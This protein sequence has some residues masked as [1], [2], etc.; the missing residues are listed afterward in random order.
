MRKTNITRRRKNKFHQ[1]FVAW[2]IFG[3][4]LLFVYCQ[5]C[6]E[7]RVSRKKLNNEKKTRHHIMNMFECSSLGFESFSFISCFSES[8]CDGTV[9]GL[10]LSN[11]MPILLQSIEQTILSSVSIRLKLF[12][13]FIRLF[14]VFCFFGDF[15]ECS[16]FEI[17]IV[18]SRFDC[19]VFC[20]SELHWSKKP[21]KQIF[22]SYGKYWW[23]EMAIKK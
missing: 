21:V 3:T 7:Y 20:F 12:A 19:A 1:L 23:L 6:A 14:F 11:F 13:W 16:H 15:N 10:L 9:A 8:E 17:S 22:H 4:H 5:R 18:H 2:K